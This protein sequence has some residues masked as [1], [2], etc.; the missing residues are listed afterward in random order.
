L[1]TTAASKHI[2]EIERRISEI[3]ERDR[4]IRSTLP[5]K[6]MPN[7]MIIELINFV[8]LLINTFPPSTGLSDTYIPRATTTGVALD[9]KNHRKLHVGDYKEDTSSCVLTLGKR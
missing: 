2:P 6:K 5:F 4:A 8:V 7:M 1:S 3:K 9:D